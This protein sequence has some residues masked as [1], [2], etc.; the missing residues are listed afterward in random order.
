MADRPTSGRFSGRIKR[1]PGN[2]DLSKTN[3]P[4]A[5]EEEP[6]GVRGGNWP[7]DRINRPRLRAERPEDDG[8]FPD[9]AFD[10]PPPLVDPALKEEQ[11]AR[12]G[13]RRG[14]TLAVALVALGGFAAIVGYAYTLGQS[15]QAAELI[16]LVEPE[17]GPI[18]QKPSD[19]GGLDV[20]HTD[21]GVLNDTQTADTGGE[22]V[23]RL[24]P[25]PEQ[26]ITPSA[27]ERTAGESDVGP[28][29]DLS[30]ATPETAVG[31]ELTEED[32]AK[33]VEDLT[34]RIEELQQ[35]AQD[36][37]TGQRETGQR[38]TGQRETGQRETAPEPET[39]VVAPVPPAPR[40]AQ[41]E[42]APQPQPTPQPT[43]Q[44]AIA[45]SAPPAQ[46]APSPT[47]SAR[48]GNYRIQLAALRSEEAARSEWDRLTNRYPD[49]LEDLELVIV[50]VTIEGRGTFFRIQGGYFDQAGAEAACQTLTAQGQAC[51]VRQ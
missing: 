34:R 50:P 27:A 35:V 36:R 9:E 1:P 47:P 26:P 21:K 19:P 25:E 32:L 41:S 29:L 46:P 24:L 2:P 15:E 30:P 48:A 49:L 4:Q 44:P 38:E 3:D 7:E 12:R 37:E 5:T 23:E 31:A 20:P 6:G 42:P 39:Q 16:P 17:T 11:A 22:T 10:G 13:D 40:V 8:I 51:I 33:R 43:P 28:S 45:A 14:L 18:K